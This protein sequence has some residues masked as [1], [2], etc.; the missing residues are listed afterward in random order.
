VIF[1]FTNEAPVSERWLSQPADLPAATPVFYK[2]VFRVRSAACVWNSKEELW[3]GSTSRR[4][5]FELRQF[6]CDAARSSR[7]AQK[8]KAPR[9]LHLFSGLRATTRSTYDARA[10]CAVKNHHGPKWIDLHRRRDMRMILTHPLHETLPARG[11][12]FFARGEDER[13]GSLNAISDRSTR[14]RTGVETRNLGS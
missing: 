7:S 9:E 12:H 8:K 3:S 13:D 2:I 14:W 5:R 6:S 4:T 10:H 1:L 11:I